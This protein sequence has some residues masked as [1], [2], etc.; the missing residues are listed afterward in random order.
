MKAYDGAEICEL[1]GIFMLLLLTRKFSSNNIGL[2]RDEG[3]SV[4]MNISGQ[5]AEKHKKTIQNIFKDKG[6][7]II[8]KCN[9]KIVDYLDATLNLND[10]IYRLFH[11]T[12]EET[13]Y[14][15]TLF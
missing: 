11:K 15:H 12:N 8:I 4:F 14:I 13:N 1:V 10:S 2:Y 7:Q 9:L 6:L 5:Q 3:L